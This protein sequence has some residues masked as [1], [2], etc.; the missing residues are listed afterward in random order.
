[1]AL[2]GL[3]H[4]VGLRPIPFGG[5]V[6]VLMVAYE[7]LTFLA[8]KNLTVN[9]LIPEDPD[10][11]SVAQTIGWILTGVILIAATISWSLGWRRAFRR[12]VLLF[13]ALSTLA[14]FLDV[15]DLVSTMTARTDNEGALNLLWDA[16]LTWTSNVL[17]FA[18]WYWFLDGGGP[19]RRASTEPGPADFAFPQHTASLPGWENWSPGILD[20]VFVAFNTSTAFSP[21]DTL[22]LSRSAKFL[23]MVQASISLV[24]I[25]MLAARVVN[26]IQ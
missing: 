18:I 16:V 23:C 13:L 25:A 6:L 10:F 5:Q 7:L 8:D 21:T 14:V 26:T 11:D 9:A 17:T 1:M 2:R 19:D 22:V 3:A 15:T 12:T 24:I 20:Y 4:K